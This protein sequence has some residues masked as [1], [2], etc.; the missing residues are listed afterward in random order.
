MKNSYK[1]QLNKHK[2]ST[3]DEVISLHQFGKPTSELTDLINEREM[4]EITTKP[5]SK[6][7]FEVSDKIKFSNPKK[8]QS[9]F[10]YI[11]DELK[12]IYG[13]ENGNMMGNIL[14]DDIEGEFYILNNGDF[15][16][17]SHIIRKCSQNKWKKVI[18]RINIH[19][20]SERQILV[21]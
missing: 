5:L 6:V 13:E 21:G 9:L 4:K 14:F 7:W 8:T 1:T 20:K 16:P 15:L 17:F 3:E 2:F 12:E 18:D 11:N 19:M 10:K